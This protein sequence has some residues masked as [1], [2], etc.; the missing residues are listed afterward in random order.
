LT[1]TP[2][3][4]DDEQIG[5][6][7]DTAQRATTPKWTMIADSSPL[8]PGYTSRNLGSF[9][10]TPRRTTTTPVVRGA[11]PGHSRRRHRSRASTEGERSGR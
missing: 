1:D 2:V 5:T 4:S 6:T 11:V 10:H 3:V 9:C 7:L 8:P